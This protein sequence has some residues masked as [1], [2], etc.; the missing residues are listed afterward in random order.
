MTISFTRFWTR[1]AICSAFA[2]TLLLSGCLE[3]V[4]ESTELPE[5]PKNTDY[6]TLATTTDPVTT[7]TTTTTTAVIP[8]AMVLKNVPFQTQNGMLPTGCELVSALMMLQYHDVNVDIDAVVAN[9]N[10]VYPEKIERNVYAPHPT[11]AFIGSPDDPTSF[12]CYPP[13]ITDM[14]SSLLPDSLEAV[15]TTGTDL[16]ELAETYLPQGLPVLVWATIDMQETY[17]EIGWY[18]LDENNQPT[19]EWFYWKAREHCLLLI[20]YNENYYFFHDP[21]ADAAP[22]PYD[23]ALVE[24]RFASLGKM[25]AVV[26]PAQ[27]ITNTES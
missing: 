7:T 22:T 21:L 25:S 14:M 4:P 10:S 26:R 6:T 3:T 20:G 12:G 19:D 27:K 16:K 1:I 18:L 11:K 9:T 24:E 13:V 23:R 15:E 2:S 8:D 17:E 5:M